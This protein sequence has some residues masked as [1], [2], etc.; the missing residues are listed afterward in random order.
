MSNMLSSSL[1]TLNHSTDLILAIVFAA[2]R[3]FVSS[4]C[5]LI[6]FCRVI[7]SNFLIETACVFSVGE[8]I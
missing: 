6:A 1:L 3:P 2:V 4:L 7:Y 5:C 8:E